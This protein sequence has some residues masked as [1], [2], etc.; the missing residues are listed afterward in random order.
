LKNCPLL[1]TPEHARK[2][3][4]LLVNITG[5]ADLSLT[6]VNELMSAVTEQF[7]PEA[8]VVMG[9]A[10][11]EA[12]QGRVE[13]CVM[14]TTDVGSRNF[15][16]RA[17]TTPPMARPGKP[18][19]T[20]TSAAVESTNVKTTVTTDVTGARAT[21]AAAVHANKPKQEEFGFQGEP[22]ENRGAFDKSDRNLFEGQDLDVPTYL[23]KGIK[24]AL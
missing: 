4:R 23:R 18:A 7:G 6:K 12:L 15:V 1:H 14:G 19:A 8:H 17:G 21:A 9:A 24:V 13:I 16:R 22:A 20:T 3:D 10:I 11:D 5:G 2:A